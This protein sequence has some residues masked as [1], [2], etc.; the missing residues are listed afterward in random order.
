MGERIHGVLS[1]VS[2][3]ESI[4]LSE[5]QHTSLEWAYPTKRHPSFITDTI[6]STVSPYEGWCGIIRLVSV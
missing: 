6:R 3:T 4:V 5:P 1:F 2:T